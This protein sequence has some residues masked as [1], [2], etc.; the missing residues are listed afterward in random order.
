VDG[1]E[2][3]TLPLWIVKHD[4]I[5]DP[6]VRVLLILDQMGWREGNRDGV[7]MA[8]NAEIAA[9][10]NRKTWAVARSLHR[11]AARGDVLSF[12]MTSATRR[13]PITL[14]YDRT[15]RVRPDAPALVQNSS[16]AEVALVQNSPNE[17]AALERFRSN[18]V[19]NSPNGTPS[20]VQ[21]SPNLELFCTSAPIR[22]R[23]LQQ[24]LLEAALERS[25]T[26]ASDIGR[27]PQTVAEVMA[28]LPCIGVSDLDTERLSRKIPAW[29]RRIE[30][31][32]PQH[33]AAAVDWVVDALIL[34]CDKEDIVSYAE[35]TLKGYAQAGGRKD[36]E[37]APRAVAQPDETDTVVTPS[38]PSKPPRS[39]YGDRA[40]AERERL[41][42]SFD[43][44]TDEEIAS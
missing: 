23:E 44:F 15:G 6:D 12:E 29:V 28:W 43:D 11:L 32:C 34:A 7:V 35:A 26:S 9:R 33:A 25:C 41:I 8:S 38:R 22:E 37:L 17:D 42:A 19:Q 21:N 13:G 40:R 1:A 5:T 27:S 10:I 4:D 24:P 3:V 20:L 30:A 36:V 16:S 14:T 2:F 31:R 18:L 39:G